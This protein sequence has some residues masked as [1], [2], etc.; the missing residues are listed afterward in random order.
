MH[1]KLNNVCNPIILNATE[2]TEISK[3]INTVAKINNNIVMY[4]QNSL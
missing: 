2:T 1:T 3:T 4:F